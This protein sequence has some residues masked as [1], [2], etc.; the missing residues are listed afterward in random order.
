MCTDFTKILRSA[1]A[2]VEQYRSRGCDGELETLLLGTLRAREFVLGSNHFQT[3]A[4]VCELAILYEAQG[5][6][7]E[8]EPLYRRAMEGCGCLHSARGQADAAAAASM[9][10]HSQSLRRSLPETGH[11]EPKCAAA[12]GGRV[13]RDL[14]SPKRGL[15]AIAFLCLATALGA[16]GDTGH[17]SKA[18]RSAVMDEAAKQKF[19]A[20]VGVCAAEAENPDPG[21]APIATT[22]AEQTPEASQDFIACMARRGHRLLGRN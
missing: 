1:K 6:H 12:P 11:L 15:L 22:K 3:L 9:L 20:D 16:C 21:A 5:R 2:D 17:N 18:G 19:T 13:R 10:Q 4:T 7:A 14:E 8:A